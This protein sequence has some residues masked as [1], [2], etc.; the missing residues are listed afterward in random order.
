MFG[1]PLQDFAI[2]HVAFRHSTEVLG[3]LN[4]DS[5]IQIVK[6]GQKAGP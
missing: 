3:I 1:R 6:G 2:V 5:S 4:T